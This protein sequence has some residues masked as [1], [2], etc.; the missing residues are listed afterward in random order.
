MNL[1]FIGRA[2]PQKPEYSFSEAIT[3]REKAIID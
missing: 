3:Y 1:G 2:S